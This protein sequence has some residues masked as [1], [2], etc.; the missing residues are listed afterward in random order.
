MNRR[1]SALVYIVITACAFLSA[2]HAKADQTAL[3]PT[4]IDIASMPVISDV[5]ISPDGKT[6]VYTLS[7]NSFDSMA[8]YDEDDHLGGWTKK[9]QL[10][11]LDVESRQI[12]QLTQGE[13]DHSPQWSPN[14]K[15]IAFLRTKD[16]TTGLCIIPVDGG[17]GHEID[18]GE[19]EPANHRWSPDGSKIAFTAEVPTEMAEKERKW[20]AG[21]AEIF[22]GEW[23]SSQIWTV[24]VDDGTVEQVTKGPDHIVEYCWSPGGDGFAIVSAASSDPYI[25]WS[26]MSPRIITLSD[27]LIKKL[28]S[29]PLPVSQIQYSPDGQYLSY[30]CLDSGLSMMHSLRIHNLKTSEILN[31]AHD[32][33]WTI[34]DYVW[35]NDSKS[36]FVHTIN[37]TVSG[38]YELSIDGRT[39]HEFSLQRRVLGRQSRRVDNSGRYL[40]CLSE[41]ATEPEEISILDL[42]QKK[43]R[44]LSAIKAQTRDWALATAEIVTWTNSEGVALEGILYNTPLVNPGRPAPLMV[45]P[46]GGPDGVSM[47]TFD[48]WV[49][50]FAAQGYSVFRPNYRGGLGYGF[51]FYA[52]NRGRLGEIEWKDI[53]SGVDHLIASGKADSNHLVYGGWSWGG[54]LTAWAIGHTDRYRAAVVGAG[55]ADVRNQYVVSDINHG[56]AA[57]WEFKGNP[58]E[59]PENFEQAN[60]V[61]FL[62]GATIPTLII[63]GREDERVG[64][65]QG[66]SL[67]RAL[68]DVNCEV[69]FLVYPREPH[70]FKEPAHIAGLLDAWADW[71]ARHDTAE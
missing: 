69:K 1:I 2:R 10:W 27:S 60:P 19:L 6:I 7:T 44:V 15:Q 53:E 56:I 43:L 52:A 30:I 48:T 11:T 38:L 70:G 36:L 57:Q 28:E 68:R 66:M 18:L 64:F 34:T 35:A 65:V 54:Y 26:F 29:D 16:D 41:A 17:E 14:G 25:A 71:Y 55:V 47:E 39:V 67:Y 21:G 12:K 40:A 20:R 37:R 61:R 8:A 32:K 62:A 51:A 63:H 4:A 5:Q 58:W 33:D 9:Q 23:K 46:H 3:R 59:Q 49:H 45:M 13:K 24:A 50:F 22:E 31:P 42:K